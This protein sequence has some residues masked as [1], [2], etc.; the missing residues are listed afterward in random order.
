MYASIRYKNILTK[1]VPTD[2]KERLLQEMAIW[3]KSMDLA[4]F[5]KEMKRKD[6]LHTLKA[7]CSQVINKLLR[8]DVQNLLKSIDTNT[9]YELPT[10]APGTTLA[11]TLTVLEPDHLLETNSLQDLLPTPPFPST[12]Q[13]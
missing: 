5:W 11:S 6:T 10:A 8:T 1:Y 3:M 12:N 7:I 2:H 4:E 9:D 13:D